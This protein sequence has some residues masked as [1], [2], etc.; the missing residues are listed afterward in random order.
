M[1][2]ASH[3]A[4]AEAEAIVGSTLGLPPHEHIS[5]SLNEQGQPVVGL[6]QDRLHLAEQLLAQLNTQLAGLG[7]GS[8][9][10][11]ALSDTVEGLSEAC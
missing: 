8:V 4:L 11:Q 10:L 1:A 9:V 3:F 2:P 6:Q 5:V 7:L